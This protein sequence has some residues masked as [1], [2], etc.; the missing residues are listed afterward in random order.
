MK[1]IGS[2]HVGLGAPAGLTC[3][4]GCAWRAQCCGARPSR[5]GMQQQHHCGQASRRADSLL[6]RMRM[7]AAQHARGAWHPHVLLRLCMWAPKHLRKGHLWPHR[8]SQAR[9]AKTATSLQ[10][11]WPHSVQRCARC[12]SLAVADPHLAARCAGRAQEEPGGQHDEQAEVGCVRP[13]QEPRHRS[14]RTS[15]PPQSCEAP[16]NAARSSQQ[17]VLSLALFWQTVCHT[18]VTPT[19]YISP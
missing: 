6:S 3:C 8:Q 19:Q 15:W 1:C 9:L 12:G 11:A 10:P 5:P 4:C 13:L 17:D 18:G 2:A 7:W 16:G 14:A